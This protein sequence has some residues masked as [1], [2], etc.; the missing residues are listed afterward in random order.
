VEWW[1]GDEP[2][3]NTMIGA[4]YRDAGAAYGESGGYARY[5]LM[6]GVALGGS[7]AAPGSGTATMGGQAPAALA[8]PVLQAS[9]LPDGSI[10]HVVEPGQTLWTI[11]A[12]YGI[13]V[14]TLLSLNG[15]SGTP[16]LHPGDRVV[17]R[18]AATAIPTIAPAESHSPNPSPNPSEHAP[19][20]ATLTASP[21]PEMIAAATT[22]PLA[23]ESTGAS[24]AV[25]HLLIASGLALLLAGGWMAVRRQG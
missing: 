20:P 23:T 19:G 2:H 17:V 12:V 7:S 15:F 4:Q 21:L 22:A 24:S 3:L 13:D 25:R 10:I 14:G 5:T 9:P 11:A 8:V 18:A 16:I 6:A 1:K